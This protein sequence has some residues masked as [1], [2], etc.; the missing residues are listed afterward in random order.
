MSGNKTPIINC[1]THIFTGDNVPPW[2]AKSIMPWPLFY[3]LNLPFV[4]RL[5]G[6]W[7]DGPGSIRFT[8][9][10]KK[11]REFLYKSRMYMKRHLV[12][13]FLKTLAGFYVTLNALFICIY[14]FNKLSPAGESKELD[15]IQKLRDWLSASGIVSENLNFGIE[16]LFILILVLF[17]KTGRNLIFFVLRR[18]W[19][20]L[21]MI[22]GKQTLALLNRYVL[23]GRFSRFKRQS[24]I[25]SKLSLQYPPGS[26]F[27][28][29]PMDM[30]YMGAGKPAENIQDQLEELRK[31][32]LKVEKDGKYHLYP[33][34][35]ADPRRIQEDPGFFSYT[36][37]ENGEVLPE[38]GCLVKKWLEKDH[39]N[40]IKI[41]PPLGYYPFDEN[42]LPLWKYAADNQVPLMAHCCRGTIHF[43]GKKRKEWDYHPV[44]V[45]AMGREKDAVS[46]GT[47]NSPGK[48][49]L[50][51]LLL[52]EIKNSEFTANFTHPMNYLCLLDERLL[53]KV[54]AG[55]ADNRIKQIFGYKNIETP[56]ERNLS[57]LKICF[58]HFG[59]D[60]EWKRFLESDRD[61]NNNRIISHPS[62]GIEFLVSDDENNPEEKPG[63]QEQIWKY[64]DWYSV[65]CSLML[66]FPNVYADIS[67][68][69]YMPE[70]MPVLKQTLRNPGLNGKVL[71]GTDFYVV[72]NN[73]SDKA[74]LAD[75]MGSLN[76]EEFDQ[77]ARIN[78]LNYLQNSFN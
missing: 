32:K 72:R 16:L 62:R 53:R 9:P 24:G 60:D 36:P 22:P 3:L 19:K 76:E 13:G 59:G 27:I 8:L 1:H 77:I 50:E 49:V 54:V 30:E 69:L 44:F 15:F 6:W 20:F 26:G 68:I 17:F 18:F 56:L 75:V 67:Y 42:L 61:I 11:W 52:P 5:I 55:S 35:F 48:L 25:F 73:K 23:I 10:A 14:W 45:Q 51:K 47:G 38:K 2:L 29:L 21:G 31:L 63:K 37:G 41:Y 70:I 64:A 40:G 78:P 43:R 33:F 58:G 71:F 57:H 39:F 4:V 46:P 7:F 34:I 74:L 66:Q 12:L 65:I 28:V